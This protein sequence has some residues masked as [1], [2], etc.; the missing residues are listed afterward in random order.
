MDE[1]WLCQEFIIQWNRVR[2]EVNRWFPLFNHLRDRANIKF[3]TD[4]TLI[5]LLWDDNHEDISDVIPGGYSIERHRGLIEIKCDDPQE[6]REAMFFYHPYIALC[7]S[8][9]GKIPTYVHTSIQSLPLYI[10]NLM[11]ITTKESLCKSFPDHFPRVPSHYII[12]QEILKINPDYNVEAQVKLC[13]MRRQLLQQLKDRQIISPH[14]I[15]HG[16]SIAPIRD[17]IQLGLSHTRSQILDSRTRLTLTFTSNVR[18]CYNI[19]LALFVDC[20]ITTYESTV[21]ITTNEPREY[22]TT[23]YCGLP[24]PLMSSSNDETSKFMMMLYTLACEMSRIR[25]Q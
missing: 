7:E 1:A 16:S 24:Y 14:G 6:I 2:P 5:E 12:L 21:I 10:T 13:E 8:H 4:I 23:P 11:N 17:L 15:L 18:E 9:Q 19:C 25:L 3:Y 20:T 22:Q